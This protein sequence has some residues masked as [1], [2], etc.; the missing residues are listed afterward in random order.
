MIITS[1]K[2]QK[3]E[4]AA[5]QLAADAGKASGKVIGHALELSDFAT[6]RA[7]AD[8]FKGTDKPLN[9]LINNAGMFLLD[10]RKLEPTTDG[11]EPH[12]RAN[13]LG[14]FLLTLLL[15]PE[16]KKAAPS[17]VVV[18]ASDA[19]FPL[20]LDAS[21]QHDVSRSG[22]VVRNIKLYGI[23]ML[24]NITFARSLAKKLHGSGVSV[25]SVNPGTVL[26]DGTTG[27]ERTLPGVLSVFTR[28]VGRKASVAAS[29]V[30]WVA[31]NAPHDRA[32]EYRDTTKWASPQ[33]VDE[34]TEQQLWRRSIQATNAPDL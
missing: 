33:H 29:D 11:H 1:R 28:V 10:G 23:R 4:E 2:Q 9:L 7:L 30:L 5:R 13:H 15:V 21:F 8:W 19:Q 14:T 6:V 26:T 12:F 17:R 20:D 18:L 25:F 16:L 24:S 3:A 32:G 31:L 34:E 22:S 27:P